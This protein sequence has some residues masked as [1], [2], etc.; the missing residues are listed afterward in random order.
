MFLFF[1]VLRRGSHT[2]TKA[3]LM[4]T[5]LFFPVLR[6]GSIF[7]YRIKSGTGFYSSPSCD[8]DLFAANNWPPHPVFLFFPVLRRG[9][10][11]MIT[12][13]GDIK[14]L[15]F[16]VL[17]RGSEQILKKLPPSSFYS[18]PSCDGDPC[19]FPP[20]VCVGFLFFPVL[21]RGSMMISTL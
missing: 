12:R 5:F 21:R 3:K 6:R 15:F 7:Q 20:F 9:S 11:L 19:S 10:L 18:S 17:R 14:F 1:P 16:P 2:L 8:G 4:Q 13:H